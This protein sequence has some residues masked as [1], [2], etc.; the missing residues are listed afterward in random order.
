MGG[1]TSKQP[2]NFHKLYR[3]GGRVWCGDDFQVRIVRS[4]GGNLAIQL[5]NA[6]QVYDLR[7]RTEK[8]V[9]EAVDPQRLRD[10]QKEASI[11]L[12]AGVHENVLQLLKLYVEEPVAYS[13]TELAEYSLLYVLER[14]PQLNEAPLARF[15]RGI[16]RALAHLHEHGVLHRDVRPENVLCAGKRFTVK[17]TG[18]GCACSATKAGVRGEAGVSGF[19]SPEMC[20]GGRCDGR[21]DVW[22]LG[23]IAYLLFYGDF[24]Y[25]SANTSPEG[26]KQAIKTGEPPARFEP[27]AVSRKNTAL[28]TKAESFC[29]ELL[30]RTP[31]K[32]RTAMKALE[33]PYMLEADGS[34]DAPE[35]DGKRQTLL[36]M[37][38]GA[39]VNGAFGSHLIDV[40]ELDLDFYLNFAQ[41]KYHGSIVPWTRPRPQASLLKAA[42][43]RSTYNLTEDQD[44]LPQALTSVTEMQRTLRKGQTAADL[45]QFHKGA[46]PDMS[47]ALQEMR[48][49]NNGAS[50]HAPEAS[51]TMSSSTLERGE[52]PRKVDPPD[53]L[54]AK[55]PRKPHAPQDTF[56]RLHTP[57]PIDDDEDMEVI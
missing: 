35:V 30:E 34:D 50:T 42:L 8:G 24:P 26:V 21:T 11:W 5:D 32:R 51:L 31:S 4:V 10:V 57:L 27:W 13:V 7:V 22:S 3:V 14:M 44:G 47:L 36:P 33:L 29:R 28:S 45:S 18:F 6:V 37:L 48:R 46:A 12:K 52:S 43:D 54:F 9:Q 2:S 56:V 39:V 41:F 20:S 19:M 16:C 23:V 25:K 1:K 49:H 15:F 17:L 53:D 40:P 55:S 38:C